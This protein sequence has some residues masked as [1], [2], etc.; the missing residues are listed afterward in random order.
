MRTFQTN[1]ER[2][3]ALEQS[4]RKLKAGM[5]L[6]C[7]MAA[8]IAI[9]GAAA[10]SPKVIIAERFVLVDETGKERAELSSNPKNV[11]FQLMNADQSRA[12]ILSSGSEGNGVLL[13]DKFGKGRQA[14]MAYKDATTYSVF[15]EDRPQEALLILDNAKGTV[16]AVRDPKGNEL[17]DLG[18]VNGGALAIS[19]T[20]GKPRAMVGTEGIT[21]F[22]EA[23]KINW[24]SF[25]ETL[26]PEER[27]H[28]MDL[29][30][31]TQQP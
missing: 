16:L 28:V 24:T 19:D 29:I 31:S 11:A 30:N 23:G 15:R 4:N 8:L 14:L 26:T 5:M 18:V 1:E 2:F 21:T 12:V 7:G 22:D 20:N 9:L 3:A 13:F 17:V 25:G 10:P 6:L 27:K